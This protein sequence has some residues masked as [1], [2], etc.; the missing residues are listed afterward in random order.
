MKSSVTDC[1]L[2]LYADDTCL[3]FTNENVSSI[4][5][6]VNTDFNSFCEWLIDN[7]LSIY[8]GKIKLNVFYS[9][10]ERKFA[11]QK[12]WTLDA[13]YGRLDCGL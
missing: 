13:L 6:H 7:K 3:L 10:R 5:K 4:E 12:I 1:D 9:K 2:R 11:Y 8:L